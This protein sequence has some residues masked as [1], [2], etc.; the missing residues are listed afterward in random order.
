[1]RVNVSLVKWIKTILSEGSHSRFQKESETFQPASQTAGAQ[2]GTRE[3]LLQWGWSTPHLPQ[4]LPLRQARQGWGWGCSE[5]DEAEGQGGWREAQ[6]HRD[7]EE[8]PAH[9]GRSG[10][11]LQMWANFNI[12][13]SKKKNLSLAW[14]V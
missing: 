7:E 10:S 9:Q 8:P 2:A 13:Y 11:L 6:T 3:G 4:P 5:E 14:S 12:S 1:M